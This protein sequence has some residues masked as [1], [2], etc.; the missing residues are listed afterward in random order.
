MAL[1]D[2]KKNWIS[3]ILLSMPFAPIGCWNFW[4]NAYARHT[5]IQIP[6][7]T[8]NAIDSSYSLLL[9]LLALLSTREH[10][11]VS[12][13][14]IKTSSIQRKQNSQWV[15]EWKWKLQF[16]LQLFTVRRSCVR[17]AVWILSVAIDI[18]LNDV[19]HSVWAFTSES[20]KAKQ[21]VDC[22]LMFLLSFAIR[23]HFMRLLLF[24]FP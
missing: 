14:K 9:M 10:K 22:N 1:S 3:P 17:C 19:W 5:R 16:W 13:P 21:S 23:S 6:K 8:S 24:K 2:E 12:P 4:L 20:N 15:K 18:A 7:P 11:L